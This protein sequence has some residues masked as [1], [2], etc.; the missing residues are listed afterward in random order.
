MEPLRY[1]SYPRAPEV[2]AVGDT[3]SEGPEGPGPAKKIQVRRATWRQF[4]LHRADAKAAIPGNL[5][6]DQ[7]AW[8]IHMFVGYAGLLM[9]AK[10]RLVMPR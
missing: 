3:D 4:R 9:L 6:Q 5:I 2:E 7:L 1:P 8:N 10:E